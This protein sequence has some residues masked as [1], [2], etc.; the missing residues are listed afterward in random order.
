[1]YKLSYYL[2]KVNEQ[3]KL[4]LCCIID[5][6]R[7]T[8]RGKFPAYKENFSWNGSNFLRFQVNPYITIDITTLEDKKQGIQT[9]VN[10]NKYGIFRFAKELEAMMKRFISI[11]ELFY[12]YGD[13][14]ILNKEIVKE[15]NVIAT[16]TT[17]GKRIC[18]QPTVVED[19]QTNLSH[20]G[21]VFFINNF[22]NYCYLTYAEMEYLYHILNKT[23]IDSL[24]LMMIQAYEEEKKSSRPPIKYEVKPIEQEEEMMDNTNFVRTKEGN[25][26]PNI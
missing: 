2:G 10:L 6:E 23:D 1:M 12:Y 4:T 26:I 18:I 7:L 11:K 3:M 19:L 17:N 22:D 24:V 9:T 13:K 14:L 5:Q 15:K 21:I 16:F 25:A 20:E 8:T